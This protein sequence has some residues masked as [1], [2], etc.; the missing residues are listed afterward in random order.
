MCFNDKVIIFRKRI[1]FNV[2]KIFV[3]IKFVTELHKKVCFLSRTLMSPPKIYCPRHTFAPGRN[4]R[5]KNNEGP[6]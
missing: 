2:K 3:I 6:G 4:Y 1:S 5:I